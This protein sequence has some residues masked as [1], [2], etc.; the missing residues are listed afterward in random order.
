[1]IQVG[2][3]LLQQK[4]EV[5]LI[6]E[7]GQTTR[8]VRLNVPHTARVPSSWLGDSV[9]HYEA[10]ALVVDTIGIKRSPWPVIDR[11]GTPYSDALHVVERYRLIDGEAAAAAIG[12]HR[13]AFTTDTKPAQFDIYGAKFD[14]DLTRKGLQVEVTVD[15]R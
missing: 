14:P 13:L 15:D 8:H 11:Y 1:T 6:Y 3:L 10:D 4:D 12:Q 7:N 2:V 5:V 9:G